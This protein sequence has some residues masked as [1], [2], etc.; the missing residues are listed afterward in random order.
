MA[1]GLSPHRIS[2]MMDL[3]FQGYSQS[4]IAIRLKISQSTV[5]LYL[6]KFASA[7]EA[8]G[9][10]TARREFGMTDYVSSL[11]NLSGELRR[12]GLTIEETRIGLKLHRMLQ[13]SGVPEED[14][15]DL[16]AALKK[17]RDESFLQAAVELSR[18]EKSAGQSHAEIV[19]EYVRKSSEIKKLDERRDTLETE[20]ITLQEKKKTFSQDIKKLTE[21]KKEAEQMIQRLR[22]EARQEQ[23]R[24]QLAVDKKMKEANLTYKRIE[25]LRP[26]TDKLKKLNISDDELDIYLKEHQELEELGITW[27]DFK[28]M[29][30]AMKN[31]TKE[32]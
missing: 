7:V 9:L 17:M 8:Q 18:L 5:S 32:D 3:Y 28:T 14:Y 6:S 19:S 24:I 21:V 27:E 13:A 16:I 15:G 4:A 12:S 30:E 11:H 20:C 26:L 25:A 22:N 23:L 2:R 10:E 29:L 1:L 31:E